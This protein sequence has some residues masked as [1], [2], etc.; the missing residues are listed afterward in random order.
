MQ[1]TTCGKNTVLWCERN[2]YFV[3]L[4]GGLSIQIPYWNKTGNTTVYKYYI[5]GKIA[6]VLAANPT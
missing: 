2:A 4:R 1:N 5:T 6:D 3:I